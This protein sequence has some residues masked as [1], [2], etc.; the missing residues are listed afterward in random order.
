M[1]KCTVRDSPLMATD[2]P[3]CRAKAQSLP[4]TK[5]WRRRGLQRPLVALQGPS[6]PNTRG[7][8]DQ[9]QP[10]S[11]RRRRARR[12]CCN[13]KN[14]DFVRRSSDMTASTRITIFSACWVVL[15]G[16]RLAPYRAFPHESC[17][18]PRSRYT[19]IVPASRSAV[20]T[21]A[22]GRQAG[23]VGLCQ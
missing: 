12:R 10:G 16:L 15:R 7:C 20:P 2:H 18:Y 23:T 9:R 22:Y 19:T 3:T 4:A 21:R 5:F 17:S 1:R 13:G 14:N 6:W 11:D 8:A